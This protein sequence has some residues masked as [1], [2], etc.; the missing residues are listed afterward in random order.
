LNE[1]NQDECRNLIEKFKK[2]RLSKSDTIFSNDDIK[3]SYEDV[4]NFTYADQINRKFLFFFLSYL[5]SMCP[6]YSQ[7]QLQSINNK[8]LFYSLEIISFVPLTKDLKYRI[9]NASDPRQKLQSNE[10]LK[11]FTKVVIL[12]YFQ[13]RWLVL[14]TDLNLQKSSITDFLSNN[15]GAI[16]SEELRDL[17]Q[18]LIERELK[19]N[20]TDV[21]LYQGQKLNYIDDCGFF[22][23]NYAY[24]FF[25]RGGRMD[26]KIKF[27]EKEIFKKQVLW[28]LLK[29]KFSGKEEV[30][31]FLYP[32]NET[33]FSKDKI[34]NS[35]ESQK[36]SRLLEHEEMDKSNYLRKNKY[37]RSD[38]SLHLISFPSE[39][40]PT[41]IL[42]QNSN[43]LSVQ[44]SFKEKKKENIPSIEKFYS[45]D[46]SGELNTNN[47]KEEAS[48]GNQPSNKNTSE[49]SIKSTSIINGKKS[50]FYNF[51]ETNETMIEL[52]EQD[53]QAMLANIKK[54][55][56]KR[57]KS[58]FKSLMK[59]RSYSEYSNLLYP[60]NKVNS[61]NKSEETQSVEEE[62]KH[63]KHSTKRK[64]TK[65]PPIQ[66][67]RAVLSWS[68]PDPMGVLLNYYGY[69]QSYINYIVTLKNSF[70][71]DSNSS[72]SSNEDLDSSEVGL[73]GEVKAIRDEE[74]RTIKKQIFG[75]FKDMVKQ[76]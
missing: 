45:K 37:V 8:F 47:Q 65:L 44:E 14:I 31:L 41:K 29:L 25:E 34:K 69:P 20:V 38:K 49:K 60:K 16:E 5:N 57:D 74:L 42:S 17:A 64:K 13:E 18:L 11:N 24:K 2:K 3:I 12:I 62:E 30:Q 1:F 22:A 43:H 56:L 68:Y 76:I 61:Y 26:V 40:V 54:D 7:T 35:V 51:A 53:I 75:V 32:E 9:Y 10:K 52:N 36:S 71:E 66:K 19:I 4:L 46:I 23:L 73:F 15:V 50:R 39:S 58:S 6:A 33:T 70:G 55:V 21:E 67:S 27:S 28:L 48:L 63:K 72:E 59:T